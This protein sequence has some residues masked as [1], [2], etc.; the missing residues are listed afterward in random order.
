MSVSFIFLSILRVQIVREKIVKMA[1]TNGS[2]TQNRGASAVIFQRQH[3]A[4]SQGT[5]TQESRGISDETYYSFVAFF[6]LVMII[7]MGNNQ[8]HFSYNFPV[9]WITKH[10]NFYSFL[11]TPAI[12]TCISYWMLIWDIKK[13]YFFLRLAN[14]THHPQKKHQTGNFKLIEKFVLVPCCMGE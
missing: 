10:A 8:L 1:S 12:M 14:D 11:K 7:K 13:R 9:A 4:R 5:A 3:T 2:I 6:V